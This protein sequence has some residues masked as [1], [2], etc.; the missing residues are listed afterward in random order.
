M[1]DEP[2]Q[3]SLSMSISSIINRGGANKINGNNRS[4][5]YSKKKPVALMSDSGLDESKTING[6]NDSLRTPM[7]PIKG[8]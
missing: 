2:S 8:S 1:K 3:A 5:Q 4:I 6:M 7:P